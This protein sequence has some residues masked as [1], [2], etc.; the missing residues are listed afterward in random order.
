M[1]SRTKIAP[2]DLPQAAAWKFII[3]VGVV[4]LFSDMTYEGARSIT[5]PFLGTLKASATVIG[6]VAGLGEF[7][8]YALR[9]A[10]GYLTDRLGKYWSIT[11]VG[12]AL[13][14]FAVPLLALAG[15]L[16]SRGLASP[17]GAHGQGHPHPGPG[18]HALPRHRRGGPGLG[19][20]FS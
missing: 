2:P 20:R 7:I 11:F 10:S 18:R 1:N 4:S 19:L 5:G 6:I 8:G 12:Y 3:L 14:L 9:L 17:D 13:N 16:G 15:R